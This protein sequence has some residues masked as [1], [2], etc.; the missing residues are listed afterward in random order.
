M[1]VQPVGPAGPFDGAQPFD[2]PRSLDGT[3]ALEP[4]RVPQ[5]SW[6]ISLAAISTAVAGLALVLLGLVTRRTDV[7]VLGVPL[8][9]GVLWT[10]LHRPRAAAGIRFGTLERVNRPGVVAHTLQF[11]AAPGV[12]A[13]L[14]RATA[15]GHRPVIA[16][17]GCERPRSVRLSIT[18][19]R[20]GE[21]EMFALDYLQTGLD[22]VVRAEAAKVPPVK[23]TVL[24]GNRPLG[25]LPL[26]SRLQGLTGPHGSR[27]PGDGGDLHDINRFASGD[28]L[29]R[30]DWR[31]TARRSAQLA[32][33]GD[34]RQLSELY[35][36]RTF[37]T[38]DATVMLVLDSRDDVG[39]DVSTWG[40]ASAVRQDEATSLDIAREAAASLA[41]AYLDAGDRVGLEDLGRMRRPVP[42]AGG[43]QQLHR[44]V[45]R[46]ALA[47]PEGEPKR[48]KRAPRMPSGALL[49]VFSTF[50][51]DDAAQ[52]ALL[53]R[54]AGHR[55]VA[56]DVLPK[57]SKDPLP[58]RVLTAYRIIRM[59]RGDR[60]LA[61]ARTGV[62]VVHWEG[63]PDGYG[64][65][66]EVEVA[67]TALA[68]QRRMR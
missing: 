61:L 48:R 62:E 35:V 4:A 9:L 50:L 32:R 59:E 57:I 54:H 8:V 10:W 28:R 40:D 3:E 23:V 42:P 19:V 30:I 66:A 63:D 26:P 44:L 22:A 17:V 16:L 49:I 52:L 68:R 64:S 5:L 18:T 13:V 20:T 38:A 6:E 29:R 36:R 67:L 24:P 34:P 60:L 33:G 47:Q 25:Q 39:P 21:R 27:R 7:A 65:E 45:Q 31:V 51:D 53:W 12:A 43:R 41:R 15:P 46:L 14:I 1:T 58:A 55:V 56:V 37:A 11:D 2:A